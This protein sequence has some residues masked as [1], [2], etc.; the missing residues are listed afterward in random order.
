M[1]CERELAASE[2]R[3][4]PRAFTPFADAAGIRPGVYAGFE[5]LR[6]SSLPALFICLSA[7]FTRLMADG[8][9]PVN[10]ADKT[11]GS[12]LVQP[13]VNAGPKTPSAESPLNRAASDSI[14]LR[15][16]SICD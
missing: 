14:T 1:R 6:V 16:V 12:P 9:S 7:A 8:K 2:W 5:G 4:L 15:R 3:R 11:C 13:G 10:R